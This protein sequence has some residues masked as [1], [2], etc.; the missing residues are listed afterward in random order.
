MNI[1]SDFRNELLKRREVKIV[2]QSDKNPGL[3]Q[4]R[5]IVADALKSTNEV[6]VVKA[7]NSRFGRDTFSID[8][9]VYDSLKDKEKIEPR[10]KVKKEVAV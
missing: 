7:L 9:F 4:S 10:L 3:E 6:V 2:L 5:K 8:A 1:T